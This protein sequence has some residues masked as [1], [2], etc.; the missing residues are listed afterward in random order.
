MEWLQ[1]ETVSR[2]GKC[3]TFLLNLQQ[4]IDRDVCNNK[5][6]IPSSSTT[7]CCKH[8]QNWLMLQTYFISE[9]KF[10][11]FMLDGWRVTRMFLAIPVRTVVSFKVRYPLVL[12]WF[13]G[14]QFNTCSI[15]RVTYMMTGHVLWDIFTFH[16]NTWLCLQSCFF[17]TWRWYKI[18]EV[19]K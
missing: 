5:N 14:W 8:I 13:L 17:W 11:V 7:K 3:H 19:G 2:G 15:V 4:T 18:L 1:M 6:C 9:G 16:V 12:L 10:L